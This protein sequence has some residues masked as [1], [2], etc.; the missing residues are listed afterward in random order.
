MAS[1]PFA[2]DEDI[3]EVLSSFRRV[4]VVGLSAD[5][6]RESHM[7]ARF[8]KERG[9]TILPVN[10][11]EESVLG[12]PCYPSLDDVPRPLEV[13][14]VFRR[15]EFVREVAEQAARLGAKALWLQEGVVDEEAAEL[16]RRAGLRVVMDRCM[17]KEWLRFRAELSRP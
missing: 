7:V 13:V 6:T 11:S 5:P 16:A 4:A 3:L 9:Y 8:L 1:D 12:E 10:P 15:S 2:S 17:L 14:D